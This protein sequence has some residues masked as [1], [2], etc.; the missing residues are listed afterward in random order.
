[1]IPRGS[2][3]PELLSPIFIV[4]SNLLFEWMTKLQ[5]LCSVRVCVILGFDYIIYYTAG[6][7][8]S[9][10]PTPCCSRAEK[11][12]QCSHLE[13]SSKH[14]CQHGH[15]GQT[16]QDPLQKKG[17]GCCCNGIHPPPSCPGPQTVSATLQNIFD[18]FIMVTLYSLNRVL[19]TTA[20]LSFVERL[21]SKD[22]SCFWGKEQTK[23][24][25]LRDL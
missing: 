8:E 3:M 15:P 22:E 6:Q 12:Y 19:C 11:A 20:V 1:M 21:R 18:R 17:K 2:F 23:R 5:E 9:L 13:R 14:S 16:G 24:L 4:W 7:R 25:Q 10:K